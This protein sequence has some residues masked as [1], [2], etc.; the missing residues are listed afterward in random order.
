MSLLILLFNITISSGAIGQL[1][2]MAIA[3]TI[4]L[5]PGMF[6]AITGQ[7]PS[8]TIVPN[9]IPVPVVPPVPPVGVDVRERAGPVPDQTVVDTHR[10][11]IMGHAR[12][13]P[14]ALLRHLLL[15]QWE[16]PNF[17]LQLLHRKV[18]LFPV[19]PLSQ[20]HLPLLP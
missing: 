1:P 2:V 11:V 12:H 7:I 15:L 5:L 8:P 10:L 17:L 14:L 3:P 18:I 19:S 6:V 20:A 4:L 16:G 13:V 9:P